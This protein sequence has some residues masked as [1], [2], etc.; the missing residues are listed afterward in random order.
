[1]SILKY[2]VKK[3]DCRKET[4]KRESVNMTVKKTFSKSDYYKPALLDEIIHKRY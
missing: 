2:F 1:M 3:L 4:L